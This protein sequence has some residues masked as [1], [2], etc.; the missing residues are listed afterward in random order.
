[1]G[2]RPKP[3]YERE[4]VKAPSAR[5]RSQVVSFCL[6]PAAEP[7]LS[8]RPAVSQRRRAQGRS[9]M[10]VALSV[11]RAPKFQATP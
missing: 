4:V 11:P 6:T 9:R 8:S 3:L 1:M 7:I 2:R 5:L 10:A